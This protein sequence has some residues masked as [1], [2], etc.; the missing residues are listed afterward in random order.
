[1]PG[2]GSYSGGSASAD[3]RFSAPELLSELPDN[4]AQL[5]QAKNVR[6]SVWT[7][8]NRIDDVQITASQAFSQS[9]IY[10]NLNPMPQT[11]G[12]LTA[13]TTFS[14]N[15]LS[16]IFD[17]LFYPYIS[18]NIQFS[19][20]PITKEY[21]SPTTVSFTFSIYPGTDDPVSSITV[22]GTGVMP[23]GGYQTGTVLH[24]SAT[25]SPT[26]GPSTS[27]SFTMSVGYGSP[28]ITDNLVVDLMWSNRGYVGN[29]NLS[30]APTY[31][32]DLTLDQSALTIAAVAS[33]CSDT[34]IKGLSF[35][36]LAT[37]FTL[38]TGHLTNYDDYLVIAFPSSF[39]TP[40]FF[41]NDNLDTS[42]TKVRSNSFSNV[43]GFSTNYD[44]WISNTKRTGTSLYTL[45][46]TYGTSS[47]VGN[48]INSAIRPSN[49]LNPIATAYSEEIKGGH[50]SYDTIL[51]RDLTIQA[52]RDWGMMATV[53]NDGTASNNGIYTL[54]YGFL[55]TDIM[56]N[57][58]WMLFDRG[59]TDIK[60]YIT[61]SE[62]ITVPYNTEYFV[63]GDLTL[64][65]EL[66]NYG[67]VVVANGAFSITGSGTFSNYGELDV[68]TI[69]SGG[70]SG[71]AVQ[72]LIDTTDAVVVPVNYEYL[73]YG[74]LEVKGSV[75]NGGKVVI[76]NGSLFLNGGT[77]SNVGLGTLEFVTLGGTSSGSGIATKY[78]IETTD[79][80]DVPLYEEYLVYG[81]LEIQGTLTNNGKVVIIDGNMIMN[82]GT[83]S[84]VS[85]NLELVSTN[86]MVIGRP[87]VASPVD[88]MLKTDSSGK[89]GYATA[90]VFIYS[91]NGNKWVIEIDDLG[92]LTTSPA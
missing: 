2:T 48:L 75:S 84:N 16:E 51:N 79:V 9:A 70:G 39:G 42:F 62:S 1:M 27:N 8:W 54:Q 6:D 89:L 28:L 88:V 41:V 15:T 73:V 45:K 37:D 20:S 52:R 5:I 22:D 83:F 58:N 47:Q 43:Y 80:I 69:G 4:S 7:L 57:G 40:D 63:Y 55:D 10:S 3:Y 18:P 49:V 50:H 35:S 76:V 24:T 33:K 21:G 64:A 25:H 38:F 14:N 90:S 29:L 86:T 12:G 36:F 11:L 30:G 61:P 32:P 34:T 92:I 59:G 78:L 19:V 56:N 44:V 81:D 31:D 26:P 53:Y 67:K 91:P 85:G 87:V 60:Y 13:G 17:E 68:I 77:F 23:T 65:G 46:H 71:L 66:I 72:Y 82:G 74:D